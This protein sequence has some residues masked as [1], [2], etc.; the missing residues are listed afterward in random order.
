MGIKIVYS[1]DLEEKSAYSLEK[2]LS[3][4]EAA[5]KDHRKFGPLYERY[6]KQIYLFV[7]KRVHDQDLC[8][9]ITSLVFMKAMTKLIQ[10][11]H[12]GYPFSAWLYR[13]AINEV[14][15]H[16]RKSKKTIT[17][18]VQDRDV[19]VMME[20]MEEK[21]DDE[22]NMSQ[23]VSALS[24]LKDTDQQLIELRFFD[25]CSFKEIGAVLNTTEGNA[26]VKTYRA[27]DKLKKLL[28]Q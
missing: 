10:Y 27:L 11:E 18:E 8:G 13:I 9:D 2:E 1:N 4:I 15:M 19:V 17:V 14:N 7:L 16:F 22:R 23:L 26:K 28:R 24:L 3:I 21:P 25:K 20:V 5:K 12:K 6:F